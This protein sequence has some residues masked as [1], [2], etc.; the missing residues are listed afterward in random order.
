LKAGN[1]DAQMQMPP[2]RE[3]GL[4]V[5]EDRPFQR[6]F[7]VV[8]RCAW[9]LFSLLLLLAMAG[10]TGAGGYLSRGSYSMPVGDVDYPRV[11]RWGASDTLRVRFDDGG[12]THRLTLGSQFFRYFELATIQPQPERAFAEGSGATFEFT[13]APP[14]RAEVTLYVRAFEPG[15]PSYR[16]GLDGTDTQLSTVILP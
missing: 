8:E 1:E 9:A 11:S 2:T 4:Q 14:G 16:L 13:A 12:P 5:E 6:A 10:L 7:W 3:D 15:F